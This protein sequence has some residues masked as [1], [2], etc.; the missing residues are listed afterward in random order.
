MIDESSIVRCAVRVE[1]VEF[2]TE[3][4][5]LDGWHSATVVNPIGR[6]IIDRLDG[7]TSL[8][9]ISANLCRSVHADYEV[10]LQDVLHFIDH[11]GR[12]G[13][14]E[15]V[16]PDD[17]AES[18]LIALEPAIVTSE[19]GEAVEDL[20][21]ID[22]D[23]NETRLLATGRDSCLLVNWSPHCGYC[24]S[25]TPT[26]AELEPALAAAGTPIVLFAYGSAGASLTQA[27]LSGWNPPVLLKPP[28]KIGPF[29]GHGTPTAFHLDASGTL[30]SA[31]ARGTEEVVALA[32]TLAGA[33]TDPVDKRGDTEIRYLL[34]RGGSC[35]PGTGSEP[36]TT[37]AGTRVYRLDGYHVGLRY[38]TEGTVELLDELFG[39]DRVEDPAAGHIYTVSIEES[40]PSDDSRAGSTDPHLLT[41]G[42]QLLVR[43]RF[44]ERVLRALLWRLDD[45]IHDAGPVARHLRTNTTAVV[46][47]VGAALLQPGLFGLEEYLQPAFARY[48]ISVVDVAIPRVDLDRRELVVPEPSVTHDAEVLRS[49]RHA[50]VIT[51]EEPEPVRPGRYPL[52][53]WGVI[54]EADTSVTRFTPAQSAAATLSFALDTD[55]PPERVRELGSLFEEVGGFG[56]W[57]HNETQLA[58]AVAEA[59]GL[60]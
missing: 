51:P 35:G 13:L 44:P 42:T 46:T 48:G 2:G 6:M 27:R 22:V 24:A 34:Q 12:R 17:E 7:S 47:P 37:W 5:L 20:Q 31:A 41:L 59:L 11:L 21:L 50:S 9:Q 32:R 30:L 52:V 57:Y 4:V 58:D 38:T 39:H 45:Q 14:L 1:A 15:G 19:M 29:L 43:S 49:M 10:V 3:L 55:D 26:L 8:Q 54:H 53:G 28:H 60:R 23:G 56:I 25:I 33:A 36:I 40:G 16:T 18:N